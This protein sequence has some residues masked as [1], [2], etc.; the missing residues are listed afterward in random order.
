MLDRTKIFVVLALLLLLPL[1]CTKLS[2]ESTPKEG[3]ALTIEK[4][5]QLNAIPSTWGNLVSVSHRPD[6]KNVFQ[7][8]FL[9]KEGNIRLVAYNMSTA[10][11]LREVKFIPRR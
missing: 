11:L 8:W 4:L 9:D 5:Q 6:F 1:S 10:Q 7:L 2:E 3:E